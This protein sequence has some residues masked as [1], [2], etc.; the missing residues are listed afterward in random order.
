MKYRRVLFISEL[1]LLMFLHLVR[2]PASLGGRN[3]GIA[4]QAPLRKTAG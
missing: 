4:I 2:S 1:G 3:Q